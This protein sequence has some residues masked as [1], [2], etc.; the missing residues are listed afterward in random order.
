MVD[1]ALGWLSTL[2][3]EMQDM[4]GK[5]T[6]LEK[7]LEDLERATAALQALILRTQDSG[8]P[9]VSALTAANTIAEPAGLSEILFYMFISGVC[10]FI[11]IFLIEIFL[12][13]YFMALAKAEDNRENYRLVAEQ[14][15]NEIQGQTLTP[16]QDH[17]LNANYVTLYRGVYPEYTTQ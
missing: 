9:L 11:L 12:G 4:Q 17:D 16:S 7:K 5:T 3:E 14:A 13:L 10:T 2:N 6:S 1:F 8:P 15:Q